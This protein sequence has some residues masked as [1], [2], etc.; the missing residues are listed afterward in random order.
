MSFLKMSSYQ[1]KVNS[2]PEISTAIFASCKNVG[3]NRQQNNKQNKIDNKSIVKI[4]GE[5]SPNMGLAIQQIKQNNSEQ[6]KLRGFSTPKILKE[7]K[8]PINQEN[9]PNI[10]IRNA[11]QVN[12]QRKLTKNNTVNFGEFIESFTEL[13]EAHNQKSPADESQSYSTSD[14]GTSDSAIKSISLQNSQIKQQSKPLSLARLKSFKD[15]NDAHDRHIEQKQLIISQFKNHND[16]LQSDLKRK[17]ELITSQNKLI[18]SLQEN[19]AT[20]KDTL[21]QKENNVTTV[22]KQIQNIKNE[23]I[24]QR[25][26]SPEYQTLLDENTFLKQS[27]N[28][29]QQN[30]KSVEQQ[31]QQY[32]NVI[33][34][35]NNWCVINS[36]SNITPEFLK[37]FIVIKIDDY[38]KQKEQHS[39]LQLA[40]QQFN[41][42]FQTLQEDLVAEQQE[43]RILKATIEMLETKIEILKHDDGYSKTFK[44]LNG[45]SM[46]GIEKDIIAIKKQIQERQSLNENKLSESDRI[47]LLTLDYLTTQVDNLKSIHNSNQNHIKS[48]EQKLKDQ[49][50]NVE[51][52]KFIQELEAIQYSAK[53]LLKCNRCN[54]Y[55]HKAITH[56]PCGH[57]FCQECYEARK[58]K[59]EL[60]DIIPQDQ[61]QSKINACSVCCQDKKQEKKGVSFSVYKNQQIEQITM[62]FNTMVKYKD[63]IK[64]LVSKF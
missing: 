16:N 44:H 21:N 33:Q 61:K 35:I 23:M 15:I 53:D 56:Q 64:L 42:K 45:I 52:Y 2:L 38:K 30:L 37:E 17:N 31:H 34:N 46:E 40:N 24:E 39:E 14:T 32:L 13:V 28:K 62:F 6:S 36:N 59:I 51:K 7:T 26:E 10:L 11:S 8:S 29:V 3:T 5:K 55:L 47:T 54:Q 25:R 49:L 41:H 1:V 12:P 4:N 9:K 27:L 48:I 58:L 18:Q 50:A 22:V 19:I 43:K 57:S 60:C 63:M 20:L